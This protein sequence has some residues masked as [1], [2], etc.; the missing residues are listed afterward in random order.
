MKSKLMTN[1]IK[2][3]PRGI[4][5]KNILDFFFLIFDLILTVMEWRLQCKRNVYQ[6]ERNIYLINKYF[7]LLEVT[8]TGARNGIGPPSSNSSR[9]CIH[10]RLM[11]L[12]KGRKDII[13]FPRQ[14]Q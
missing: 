14:N 5:D 8:V 4:S 7:L 12:R 3:F 6:D 2:N 1:E 13:S 9:S 10:F 11:S